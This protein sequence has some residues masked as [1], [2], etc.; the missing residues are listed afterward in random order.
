MR[1]TLISLKPSLEDYAKI[2][3]LGRKRH[4]AL[5][6]R[7]IFG[8]N[9]EKA[10]RR[11]APSR[12]K[13]GD[14]RLG[15]L[16]RAWK[17]ISRRKI[18]TFLVIIALGFS[19]A[20]M[21]SVPAGAGAS[22]LTISRMAENL[23][24]T[25]TVTQEE[26]NRTATLI[27]CSTMPS[28]GI[29]I[30]GFSGARGFGF[31]GLNAS[32]QILLNE[33]IV[34]EVRSISGVK[35][36]IPMLSVPSNETVPLTVTTP[37][38]TRTVYRSAYTIVGVC[39][40]SSVIDDYPVLPT[41]IT[42]G[43]TLNEGDHGCV[44]ISENLTG[45]FR[46]GVG[47]VV[48]INGEPFTVKG[49]FSSAGNLRTVYME[50]TDAQRITGLTGKVNML[51]VYVND[52]SVEPQVA[53]ILR[54]A[55]PELYITT[56]QDRLESLQR[57]QETYTE[58]LSNAE[59]YISQVQ[60]TA[61]QLIIVS[62]AATSLIIFFVMLYSVRERTR[63][64]GILKA[65]GFSN[66]NIMSQFMLEGLIIGFLGGA[67]G[68]AL[69]SVLAPFLA[70]ILLPQLNMPSLQSPALTRPFSAHYPLRELQGIGA[71]SLNPMLILLALCAAAVLGAIG[72]L[73]P[74]WR[75]SRV[76]PM[77]ALRYE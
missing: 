27:Q 58:A 29:D 6:Y 20:L 38:G 8:F 51:Y 13:G 75:A 68:V 33:S 66:R 30:F 59:S 60:A 77:E 52:T 1:R 49:I 46:A 4:L 53:D 54:T 72:S 7:G 16:S 57:L 12:F 3:I 21:V 32:S 50:L 67:V 64:I 76:S 71:I 34:D 41:N 48:E 23:R 36:A 62:V 17:N 37:F 18:R 56:F 69:G 11:H 15:A 31:R 26:L 28:R 39:L 61:T 40:N 43:E 35:T 47:D 5:S 2:H 19:M 55:Y 25:I 10:L 14:G 24:S 70:S 42:A 44:L 45:F 22:Q 63:E 74:A 65:I 9:S 73:Y